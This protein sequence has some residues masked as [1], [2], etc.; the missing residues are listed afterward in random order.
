MGRRQQ[1]GG[2]TAADFSPGVSTKDRKHRMQTVRFPNMTAIESVQH[3]VFTRHGG[4]SQ[5]PY[6]SLNVSRH[7]GDHQAAVSENRRIV[8]D[9]LKAG[10]LAV[11]D[12]VH[13]NRV[14]VLDSIPRSP[15]NPH[16]FAAGRGDALVT[17]IPGVFLVIQTADCQAVMMVDPRKKVIANVHVGW[18][19]NVHNIIGV[20]VTTMRERF[21]CQPSDLR[22]GIGPSLGPCCAEFVNYRKEFPEALWQYKDDLNRIDL[23][24][25]SSDQ[26][27]AAGVDKENIFVS[28]ICTKCRADRFFSFR[29]QRVTGRFSSAIAL[30]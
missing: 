11:A 1:S 17:N 2:K 10:V 28:G 16:Y 8:A 18:R 12:Q 30:R 25:T 19:G 29:A 6:N 5:G 14:I 4:C 3:A 9:Y 7:I 26:L 15:E 13:G 21:G 22:A 27:W 24:K 20:T 23:W